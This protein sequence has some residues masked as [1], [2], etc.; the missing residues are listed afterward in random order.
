MMEYIG[1]TGIPMTFDPVSV[2]DGIDFHFI[3]SFAIDANSSGNSQNGVFSPYWVPTLTPE[4]VAAIKES[5]PNVKV[6]ASLS[7][8]S[9]GDTVLHWYDP[10]DPDKWVSNG[11][12]SLKSI[13]NKYHLD[14]IDID[15]ETFP[16]NQTK[17]AY[18]IGGLISELKNQSVIT[19]ATIAPFYST[20]DPYIELHDGYGDVIDYINYQFYTDK[21]RRPQGYLETFKLRAMQFGAEKLLPSYEIAGRGIQGDAFFQALELLEDSGFALNGV[22]IFSADAG[23]QNG[24]YYE[25]ESQAFL[26]NATTV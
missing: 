12:S 9:L 18:C 2:E 5:H 21:V 17:F 10:E 23:S 26:L 7:G 11:V 19:V 16:K 25:R 4:G 22:M 15:Y 14:G 3:L 1:A 24:Y 8:W 13:I 20:T 6:M